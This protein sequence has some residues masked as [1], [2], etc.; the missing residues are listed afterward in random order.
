M[1]GFFYELGRLAGPSV[2]KAKWVLRSLTGTEAEA[3]QAEYEAGRDLAAALAREVEIDSDAELGQLLGELGNR[4]AG[5]V[6]NKQRRFQF[7]ALRTA[8]PNAFALPGGFVFVT[9]PLVELCNRDRAELAFI[10]GHEMGHVIRKHAIDRMLANTVVSAA[11][12]AA[13]VAGFVRSQIGQ[14]VMQLLEQG[15]SQDQE[16][17]ADVLGV[18][19]ARSAGFD[20]TAAVRMLTRLKQVCAQPPGPFA[21]FSSHPSFDVR[22]D[23]VNRFLHGT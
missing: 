9:R 10:L 15:Y 8:D 22:I 3:I 18:R 21:Y 16:L 7:A 23:N 17:D 2:R 19:L 1:G 11:V 6:T 13:P 14:V 5:R 4:L 20:G 12:R